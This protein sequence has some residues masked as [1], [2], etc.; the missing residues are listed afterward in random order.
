MPVEKGQKQ[1]PTEFRGCQWDD[2][3][4]F[5]APCV[6]YAPWEYRCE[7]AGGNSGAIDSLVDDVLYDIIR[8]DDQAREARAAALDRE[9]KWRGW[10]RGYSRRRRAWHV[11][12]KIEWVIMGGKPVDYSIISREESEGPPERR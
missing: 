10:G 5:D 7:G 6:V 8:G 4:E 11:T 2:G 3:W 9:A 1:L 12:I